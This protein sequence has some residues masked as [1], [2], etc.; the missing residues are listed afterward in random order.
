MEQDGGN[1]K[2][3]MPVFTDLDTDWLINEDIV[4]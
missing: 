4:T 3:L 1:A 2:Y